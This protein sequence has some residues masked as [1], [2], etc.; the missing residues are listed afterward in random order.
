MGAGDRKWAFNDSECLDTENFKFIADELLATAGARSL[1]HTHF[2]D[3]V[4]DGK[5]ITGVV[6]ES[7]SGRGVIRAKRVVDC[8]GDADVAARSGARFTKL[9]REHSMGL[10]TVFNMLGVDKE[11]FLGHIDKNPAT[12]KDWSKTWQQDTTGKE[13][14]LKSP[15]MQDEF[16]DVNKEVKQEGKPLSFGGSWS[17]ITD[18]GEATN[19]NLVHLKGF[20]PLSAKDLTKAEITGRQGVMKAVKALKD[21]IPGFEDAKL[22]NIAMTMGIR[23]SRKIVGK[24]V[25]P[26]AKPR[27]KRA[28][29]R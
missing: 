20:D 27:A 11:K 17:A 25:H 12:Y 2:V 26:R 21:T 19:L 10:T 4:M 15:Y 29:T 24:Y 22:R 1:L 18:K 6:V 7:K 14:S 5:K 3:A 23:D 16:A 9:S 8:S 28:Q 13:D